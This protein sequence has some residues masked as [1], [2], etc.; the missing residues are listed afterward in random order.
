MCVTN[1]RAAEAENVA[2]QRR[3]AS[4]YTEHPRRAAVPGRIIKALVLA[5]II[6]LEVCGRERPALRPVWLYQHLSRARTSAT[7]KH[8]CIALP[9]VHLQV[10]IL[11]Q[12]VL[13]AKPY[14]GK[15]QTS[16][17]SE[18]YLVDRLL[19][20]RRGQPARAPA[21][22]QAGSQQGRPCKPPP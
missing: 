16:T 2:T 1:L 5:L 10:C 4:G 8:Q 7:S 9:N 3:Q 11:P 22:H 19:R 17:Y 21:E 14:A 18:P 13:S 15:L 20:G 6:A 12:P